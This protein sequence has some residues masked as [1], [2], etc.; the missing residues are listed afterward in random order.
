[1]VRRGTRVRSGTWPWCYIRRS[2][3]CWSRRRTRGRRRR[4]LVKVSRT[5]PGVAADGG[6]RRADQR[7]QAIP[8]QC[9]AEIVVHRS[10]AG[11]ERIG[12]A[13]VA[14]RFGE[15]IGLALIGVVSAGGGARA[16][17]RRAAMGG[18][19]VAEVGPRRTVA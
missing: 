3:R 8:R 6:V 13:P 2:T 17:R 7:S 11:N 16:D 19:R 14:A 12:L 15:Q 4:L 10:V 1:L 9:G 18:G 5:L